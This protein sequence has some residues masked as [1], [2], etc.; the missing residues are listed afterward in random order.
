MRAIRKLGHHFLKHVNRLEPALFDDLWLDPLGL[1]AWYGPNLITRWS[2]EEPVRFMRKSIRHLL[3]A[4][5]RFVAEDKPDVARVV[6]AVQVAGLT[7]LTVAPQQYF[8]EAGLVA[9]A[10]SLVQENVG[11]LLRRAI[12]AAVYYEEWLRRVCQRDQEGMVAPGAVIG[13]VDALLALRVGPDEGA[14][15]VHDRLV[16]ELGRLLGPDSH[17]SS[18][19]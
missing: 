2:F 5:V 1:L 3:E 15:G 6:P 13:N 7:E 8:A 18:V 11:L 19:E 17:P 16:E 4:V 9:K 10:D 14:V 12:T